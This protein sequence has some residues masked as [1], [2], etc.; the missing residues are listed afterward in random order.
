M[1]QE[2]TL[3]EVIDGMD[4]NIRNAQLN[5]ASVRE[6]GAFRAAGD[7]VGVMTEVR[8]NLA[9]ESK[10]D[11]FR[12]IQLEK[13]RMVRQFGIEVLHWRREKAWWR[14]LADKN[15]DA[16]DRPMSFALGAKATLPARHEA[17]AEREPGEEG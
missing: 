7:R 3:R 2:P 5:I 1:T 12:A 8:A 17:R 16:L 9:P 4:V 10:M 6:R 15:P 11:P 13:D 14:K